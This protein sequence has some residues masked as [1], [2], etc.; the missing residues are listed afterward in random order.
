MPPRADVP[1]DRFAN[2]REDYQQD[3]QVKRQE[4]ILRKGHD[5]GRRAAMDFVRKDVERRASLQKNQPDER[6][7][8]ARIPPTR[9][10]RVEDMT[11]ERYDTRK[12]FWLLCA[13]NLPEVVRYVLFAEGSVR[14]LQQ[15]LGLRMEDTLCHVAVCREQMQELLAEW[16]EDY[17]RINSLPKGA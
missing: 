6:E 14:E 10:S 7:D 4:Y 1:I 11:I 5:C 3:I 12:L 13:D 2:S 15:G 9:L 8:P 16:E 17:R